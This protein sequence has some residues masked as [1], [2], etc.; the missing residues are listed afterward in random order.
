M[1]IILLKEVKNI[2]SR[3]EIKNVADGFACNYLIPQKFAIIATKQAKEEMDKHQKS[4][5]VKQ[6][7]AAKKKDDLFEKLK[8]QKLT[9]RAKANEE[10]KLFAA[11]TKENIIEKIYQD[12]HFKLSEKSIVLEQPLKHVGQNSVLIKIKS[13][14]LPLLL[15]IQAYDDKK[16]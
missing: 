9:F 3:G 15:E 12:Y 14:E 7:K 4:S 8:N 16:E 1:E 2:G 10:G 13:Q 5:K 11:V 6:Q